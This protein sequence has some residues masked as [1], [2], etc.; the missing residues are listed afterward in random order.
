MT[1]YRQP[2]SQTCAHTWGDMT[3]TRNR[4]IPCNHSKSS[5]PSSFSFTTARFLIFLAQ[6]AYLSVF[7][8]SFA[9][10][11]AGLAQAIR[12]RRSRAHQSLKVRSIASWDA[13]PRRED[14]VV[15]SLIS[16]LILS[17]LVTLRFFFFRSIC[18]VIQSIIPESCS[19]SSMSVKRG[20]ESSRI[21]MTHL[22][23]VQLVFLSLRPVRT[24]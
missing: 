9:F 14:D 13:R 11:T 21:V 3:H 24:I 17:L 6:F 10:H 12:C 2:T 23:C 18:W 20:E 19:C 5:Q 7:T 16:F 22:E 1:V 8:V 15:G 4:S